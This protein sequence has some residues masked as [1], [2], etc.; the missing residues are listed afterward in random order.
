[1]KFVGDVG[2]DADGLP[3]C[4]PDG[5]G[6]FFGAVRVDVV[7][8]H[9]GAGGSQGVGDGSPNPPAGPGDDGDFVVQT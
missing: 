6:R 2:G 3:A 8:R 5:N 1:L 4:L 9:F 7:H